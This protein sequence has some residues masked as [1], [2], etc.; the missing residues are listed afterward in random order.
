MGDETF[1]SLG[2]ST[3]SQVCVMAIEEPIPRLT[4]S[5]TTGLVWNTDDWR[6]LVGGGVDGPFLR[7]L[8]LGSGEIYIVFFL[9][10]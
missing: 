8:A 4:Y 9:E 1:P 7:D 2:I 6:F 3:F 10:V 5:W